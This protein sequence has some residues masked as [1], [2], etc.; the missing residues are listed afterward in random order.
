MITQNDPNAPGGVGFFGG[1]E[2]LGYLDATIVLALW[3]TSTQQELVAILTAAGMV[4]DE[5]GVDMAQLLAALRVLFVAPPALA[6]EVA[7]REL[8]DT[9]EANTR[10][11]ADTAE[12]NAR[13]AADTAEANA[14][15]AADAA[16]ATVRGAADT[17]EANARAA[18]D[19]AILAEFTNGGANANA[20]AKFANGY[21][22]KRGTVSSTTGNGD[23]IYFDSPFPNA[24]VNVVA[25]ESEASGWL[26]GGG[27][28]PVN[29][30]IVKV[31]NTCFKLYAIKNG[32]PVGGATVDWQ[33]E[34]I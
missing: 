16:E 10:A 1:T 2:A 15:A 3:M 13:A 17:A 5:T 34:G 27:W 20:T 14:R 25:I 8:A 32:S 18:A 31:D 9:N 28:T 26:V 23:L 29:Y 21:V 30:G 24:C 4:P 7:A 22:R 12:A 6:A 11:A 33:A 19:A